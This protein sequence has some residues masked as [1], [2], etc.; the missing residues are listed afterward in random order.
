MLFD[1]FCIWSTD[2]VRSDGVE[3]GMIG[4]IILI[5]VVVLGLISLSCKRQGS[6]PDHPTSPGTSS[7]GMT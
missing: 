7:T 2:V 4:G 6:L 1:S 3:G 5:T